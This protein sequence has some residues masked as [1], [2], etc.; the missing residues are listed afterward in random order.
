[1]S[2]SLDDFSAERAR[3]QAL[4]LE[5]GTQ[6]TK[7]FYNLDGAAYRDGALPSRTKELLDVALIVGGSI[8]I[9]H[10][11]RAYGRLEELFPTA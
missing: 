7:R 8:V 4:V 6:T 11:R 3:L 9:P 5:K 2:G 1:M 10:L